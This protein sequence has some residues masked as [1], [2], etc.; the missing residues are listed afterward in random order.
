VRLV[1]HKGPQ[2]P[3]SP[4]CAKEGAVSIAL[5]EVLPLAKLPAQK[6]ARYTQPSRIAAKAPLLTRLF[7]QTCAKHRIAAGNDALFAYMRSF[8]QKQ[9]AQMELF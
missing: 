1:L 7:N 9:G 3:P 5:G 4:S 2:K 8:E 6:S